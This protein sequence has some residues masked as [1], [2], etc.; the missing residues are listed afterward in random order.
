M[1][2]HTLAGTTSAIRLSEGLTETLATFGRFRSV[3][4]R[5]LPIRY[6]RL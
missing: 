1:P 5:L 6:L 3:I 2:T 4:N